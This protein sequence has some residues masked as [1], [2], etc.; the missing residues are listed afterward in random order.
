MQRAPR[1]RASVDGAPRSPASRV[2]FMAT[3]VAFLYGCSGGLSCGDGGGCTSAYVYP[4]SGLANGVQSV[5]DGARMRMTQSALDF[6]QVHLKDILI[7]SIGAQS[8]NPDYIALEIPPSQLY[9]EDGETLDINL[10][11]GNNET[12]PTTILVDASSF[13]DDLDMR[14]VQQGDVVNIGG[15]DI[16]IAQDGILLDAY[17][18]PVGLDARLFTAVTTLGITATAGCDVDGSNPVYCPPGDP[19]CGLITGITLGILVYPSVATGAACDVPGTECVKVNVDVVRAALGEFGTNAVHVEVPPHDDQDCNSVGAPANCSPECSDQNLAEELVGLGPD[20]ECDAICAIE[21][22]GIDLVF[23][24]VGLIA[25]LLEGFLDDILQAAIADALADVDGSPLAIAGR[26]PLGGAL[27]IV[28]PSTL[29]LG[30]S[31]GPTNPGFDVNCPAGQCAAATGMDIV[32]KS[33]FEAAPDPT[34]ETSVPHPCVNAIQGAAFLGLYGGVEFAVPTGDPLTGLYE[35]APYHVGASLAEQAVN[36]A[37]FA[38]YNAG[39]LCIELSTDQVHVLANGAFPL[40]VGTLDVLTGGK[41]RQFAEPTNPV[42]VGIVPHGPPVITYGGGVDDGGHMKLSWEKAEVAFYALMYER[43]ARV[44]SVTVDISLGI[45]VWNDP[46]TLKLKIAIVDGPN[47]ENFTPVYN[48]LMPTVAFD[49]ILGD[50][51]GLMF[52]AALSGGLE[53]D[54]DIA[55][56]LSDALGVPLYVS[57]D[58]F[59]TLPATDPSFLNVYVSLTETPPPEPRLAR[60]LPRLALAHDPGLMEHI[61]DDEGEVLHTRPSGLARI[62]TEAGLPPGYEAFAVV[63]FGIARGPLVVDEDGVL[64]VRDP[65]LRIP[66]EHTIAIR[67]RPMRGYEQLDRTARTIT[68][69]VDPAPPEVRLVI[70][71]E[72]LVAR[73]SDVGTD[74]ADLRYAWIF[75]DRPGSLDD[76]AHAIPLVD[77]ADVRRVR[78][79]VTDRAG[80]QTESKPLD[81]G[82]VA[83]R[84][85]ERAKDWATAR[86]DVLHGANDEASCTAVGGASSPLALTAL[87]LFLLRRRRR[88]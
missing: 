62:T 28:S 35:G 77:L 60:E 87:A 20:W 42:I 65:K 79:V 57:M 22:F 76:T 82:W 3:L 45:A 30:Y 63:D 34:G 33:G 44:F 69:L 39:T 50:L 52:D 17:D 58:G 68:V 59:E 38:A 15:Q 23:G 10:G 66:G 55:T 56:A 53:F 19:N 36:Q 8:G 21:E 80:H 86:S 37:L 4:Q 85:S 51:I 78:V 2:A 73:A 14:F 27:P 9:G 18:I 88:R 72:S 13:V 71:G 24:L 46:E 40:S 83:A 1:S 75:D 84:P 74:V 81:L 7:A 49:A 5:D 31:I 6:L 67:T 43:F 12:Y 16:T 25:P 64:T 61:L 32:M 54:Y 47:V 41:L 70:E 29:D 26:F 11:Q 48:E